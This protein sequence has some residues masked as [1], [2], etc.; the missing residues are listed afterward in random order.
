MLT[1]DGS[2]RISDAHGVLTVKDDE[3][4]KTD[5]SETPVNPTDGNH[6]SDDRTSKP[7]DKEYKAAT[8]TYPDS[9]VRRPLI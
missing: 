9:P 6:S 7:A 2:T 3:D 8:S 1:V 4:K 5:K